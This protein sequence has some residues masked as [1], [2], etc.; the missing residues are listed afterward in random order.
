[1]EDTIEL[2]G[3]AMR[4]MGYKIQTILVDDRMR[5]D[6]Q[7]RADEALRVSLRM[8]ESAIIL[9]EVRGEEAKTLY[10][11]MRAGRA[12]SSIMG[13]IH[14]DSAESVYQRVV[15]D[16]GVSPEA[17]MATDVVIT[18]GTVKDRKSGRLIRRM[19]EMVA[20]SSDMGQFIDISETDKLMTAPVMRR[21]LKTS[22][23]G[24]KDAAKDIRARSLMRAVL[25]EAGKYDDRYLGPEWILIA[26]DILA[27]SNRNLSAEGVAD[28]LRKRI[29][30]KELN[31]WTTGGSSTNAPPSSE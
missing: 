2:P 12:G 27:K 24:K 29:G 3:E 25:A 5:G 13:T 30:I 11:S 6:Q 15:F 7:S 9:G 31:R 22:Q 23:L 26:N 4:K 19:N 20:T 18:L 10:Q 1:M 8:G 28:L 16:M 14:G 17:F 21:A